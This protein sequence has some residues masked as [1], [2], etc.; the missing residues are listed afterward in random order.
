MQLA[1]TAFVVPLIGVACFLG[2]AFLGSAHKRL[3]DWGLLVRALSLQVL[4]GV[5]LLELPQAR[6]LFEQIGHGVEVIQRF[7]E[8]GAAFVFGGLVSKPDALQ[9]LFG[10]EASFIFVLKL[11]PVLVFVASLIHMA[12]YLGVL[13]RVVLVVA[14]VMNKL[15]GVSGAE[16]LSNSASVFLGQIEAQM[17]VKPYLANMTQSELLAIM[18]GSMACISGGM[19]AIYI[20]MG[21]PSS[22]L[23][24]AS[25]MAIPGSFAIAKLFLPET[26]MP[27]TQGNFTIVNEQ[28]AV[29]LIDA[30]SQGAHEGWHV[31]VSVITMLIAFVAL[32]ALLDAGLGVLG[33]QLLVWGVP[34]SVGALDLAQLSIGSLLG[35][36]FYW[37]AIGLGIPAEEAGRAGSI[38]GTKLVLNEFV[39]Y[40][41]L[42]EAVKQG[43]FSPQGQALLSFALCG[44]AN[45]GSIGIQLGG[46][47][48]LVPER[49]ADIAKLGLLAMVAGNLASYLSAAI[50]GLL[51]TLNHS[52]GSPMWMPLAIGGGALVVLLVAKWLFPKPAY[53]A[54]HELFPPL[55]D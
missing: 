37:P 33:R 24:T 52:P 45:L 38:L 25:L 51:N 6:W 15:L 47:G 26:T 39:A 40:G 36:L 50:A 16:T 1:Y 7:A 30:A 29:N 19:M 22:W 54:R 32:V 8:K 55:K 21:V 9:Q 3:I 5:V 46:I 4:L 2:V 12:Y 13:Q 31:G 49:R 23:L 53:Y 48:A 11:L 18:A 44:F 42:M 20:S 43:A 35:Q 28:R 10:Q 34:Q 27:E 41:Q 17:L 14:W